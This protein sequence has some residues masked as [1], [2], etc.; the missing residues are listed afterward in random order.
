MA[1][2]GA[3]TQLALYG[4]VGLPYPPAPAPQPAPVASTTP[5]GGPSRRSSRDRTRYEFI[6][7]SKR[8][9]KRELRQ[10]VDLEVVDQVPEAE[11]GPSRAAR[12]QR[13]LE[14]IELFELLED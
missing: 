8:A 10:D 14:A 9:L 4:G 6:P 12:D 3:I 11:P 7:P 2:E 1:L 13:D 5:A